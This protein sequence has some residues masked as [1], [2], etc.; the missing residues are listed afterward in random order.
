MRVGRDLV[1]VAGG[2]GLAPLR[3]VV[4]QAVAERTAFERVTLLVGSRSPADLLYR[5]ELER[6]HDAGIDVLATVDHS[7]RTWRGDVG[8]VTHLIRRAELDPDATVALLCG[9]EIMMRFAADELVN[10]GVPASNIQ[11]S[12]ERNMKSAI[13]QCGHCQIGPTFVCREGPVYGYDF[14]RSLMTVRGL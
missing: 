11:V 13:A 2:L 1:I 7:D 8:V 5:D 6:W 14:A 9:P 4:L 10:L 12:L 3:P